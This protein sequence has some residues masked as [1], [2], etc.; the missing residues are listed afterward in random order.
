MRPGLVDCNIF[1]RLK[2]FRW[3]IANYEEFMHKN[4]DYFF[5]L[6]IIRESIIR[7]VEID[8]NKNLSP[9]ELL[10]KT[11]SQVCREF[12]MPAAKASELF[13]C[14]S[15]H[16]D[17]LRTCFFHAICLFLHSSTRIGGISLRK[18]VYENSPLNLC[19]VDSPNYR[20]PSLWG[21]EEERLRKSRNRLLSKGKVYYKKSQWTAITKDSEYEWTFYYALEK[22]SNVLQNTFKRIGNLYN[23]IDKA[24][25]SDKDD[26]Y[27]ERIEKAYESFVSKLRKIK[28]ENYLMLQKA[29]LSH[30]DQN[31][32]YYGLNIYRLEKKLKPYIITM[33]VNRLL[34]CQ[35][36]E[37]KIDFL[38]KSV[39]LSDIC[40]PKL[41]NDFLSLPYSDMVLCAEEFPGYLWDIAGTSCIILDELV[42]KGIFGENWIPLFRDMANGM[43]ESVLFQPDK[44]DF[45]VEKE[46]QI[47]F[48]RLLCAPVISAIR[49]ETDTRFY[50]RDFLSM[51]I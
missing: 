7:L 32:E 39:V 34:A 8:F 20:N 37:E 33:E 26:G 25:N 50:A 43:A 21:N 44:I 11:L 3:N 31:R 15:L 10:Y 13:C 36:D 35:T 27:K 48:E 9:Q 49:L 16:D 41:Y 38:E 22:A 18:F 46:S 47:N 51:S 19:V 45:T 12:K 28:Y 29:V 24:L 14:P 40:H 42:E 17:I 1:T 23:D 4:E 6:S 5:C 30:I 2:N